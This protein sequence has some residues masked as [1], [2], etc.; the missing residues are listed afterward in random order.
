MKGGEQ[1]IVPV[2][3]AQK[4]TENY[5]FS[6]SVRSG[7]VACLGEKSRSKTGLGRQD[8]HCIAENSG[9]VLVMRYMPS[10]QISNRPLPTLSLSGHLMMSTAGVTAWRWAKSPTSTRASGM[11]LKA[12]EKAA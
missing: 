7:E 6:L 1:T 11:Y 4:R 8:I 10:E 9:S 12:P 2:I 5:R 3:G